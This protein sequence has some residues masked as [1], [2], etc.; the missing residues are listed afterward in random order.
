MIRQKTSRTAEPVRRAPR[1]L[2]RI[3]VALDGSRE[4]ETILEH[5]RRLLGSRSTLILL[6]VIPTP[7]PA[8][9]VG[10][11]GLLGLEK[12]M[13]HYLEGVQG[14][15]PRLRSRWIVESGDPVERILAMAQ[16]E[17]AD[18]LALTTH[19]RS[20]LS[21]LLM[22]SAAREVVQRAGRPVFLVRPGV[23]APRRSHRRLLVP[24]DGPDG[25][26]ELL[27][28]VERL[29]KQTGSGVTLLHVLPAA[30]VADPVTGFNPVVLKP[31]RL[32]E[33]S[34]LD[35]L[36]DYLAHHGVRAVKSVQM[37]EPDLVILRES[38]A[39]SADL[40]VL[41]TRGRGGIARL[42]LGSVP[43]QVLQDADRPVLLFHRVE[44]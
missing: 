26:V 6:H 11:A 16:D 15:F 19:M 39:M 29:A 4:S 1:G 22:G 24:L 8:S 13:E 31:M 25:A 38:R 2:S 40:I 14:R 42:V 44:D 18:A 10:V 28:S 17:K 9:D 34:W 7:P 20:R 35:P 37:G 21:S 5:L 12:E 27:G 36:V 32:P 23:P 43:E 41:R 33:V 3:L 30:R